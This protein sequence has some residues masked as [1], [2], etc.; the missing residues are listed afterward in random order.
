MA[1][2]AVSHRWTQRIPETTW[3]AIKTS[4][5]LE[6][7]P[8]VFLYRAGWQARPTGDQPKCEQEELVNAC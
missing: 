1:C 8:V 2:R 6:L 4:K 7:I 3:Q 5:P